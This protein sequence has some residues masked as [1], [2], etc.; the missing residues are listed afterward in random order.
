MCDDE[1]Y[2]VQGWNDAGGGQW[3]WLKLG[4]TGASHA[5]ALEK[6]ATHDEI[7]NLAWLNLGQSA[8]T[9]NT[10]LGDKIVNLAQHLHLSP[11]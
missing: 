8:G 9:S 5:E 10:L 1:V 4:E 6:L 11:C 7:M 3:S 2:Q